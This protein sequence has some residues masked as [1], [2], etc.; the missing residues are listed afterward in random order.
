MRIVALL[1]LFSVSACTYRLGAA[2]ISLNYQT[3]LKTKCEYMAKS[4]LETTVPELKCGVGIETTWV[5]LGPS[6]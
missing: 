5:I 1:L 4:D 2:Q 6:R 3:A